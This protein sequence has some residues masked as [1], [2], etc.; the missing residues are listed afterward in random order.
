M[1]ALAFSSWLEILLFL[2]KFMYIPWDKSSRASSELFIAIFYPVY[3]SINLSDFVV[4]NQEVLHQVHP[5]LIL[6]YHRYSF[7]FLLYFFQLISNICICLVTYFINISCCIRD[8]RM[9][10]NF[11]LTEHRTSFDTCSAPLRCLLPTPTHQ[12]A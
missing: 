6:R 5:N 12:N 1:L 4:S 10:F 9:N 2:A 11:R 3:S 7:H 8:S